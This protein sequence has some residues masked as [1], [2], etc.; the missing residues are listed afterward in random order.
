MDALLLR[1]EAE[2]DQLGQQ[3]PS[4][5]VAERLR[6][7][8]DS[9]DEGIGLL[10]LSGVCF[11]DGD[12]SAAL[13]AVRASPLLSSLRHLDVTGARIA[14][15]CRRRL[16]LLIRAAPA[17]R[18]FIAQRCDLGDVGAEQLCL[19]LSGRATSPLR[20][21]DLSS[22]DCGPAT[23]RAIAHLLALPDSSLERLCL[24]GN[25]IGDEG[26]ADIAAVLCGTAAGLSKGNGA[27]SALQGPF[28]PS[29][30]L[31]SPSARR[32]PGGF[33]ATRSQGFGSPAVVSSATSRS[34]FSPRAVRN[35]A[36]LTAGS[37]AEVS[38]A[39]GAGS[40]D[41]SARGGSGLGAAAPAVKVVSAVLPV[42]VRL[43]VVVMV[44]VIM[45]VAVVAAKVT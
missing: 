21:L 6:E 15:R 41:G 39:D 20:T 25:R 17:L 38:A 43:P 26:A 9:A 11:R 44:L 8:C 4:D 19:A 14:T 16:A 2:S 12:L 3:F 29:K 40:S 13:V 23:A 36:A 10:D 45:A 30:S 28:D 7:F 33:L 32:G 34:V 35:R 18:H 1:F 22:N 5:A 24:D 31:Q 27:P 37:A 42:V